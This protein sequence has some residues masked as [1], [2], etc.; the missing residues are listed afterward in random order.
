M[1]R[2][3]INWWIVRSCSWM[4]LKAWK[5]VG[6]WNVL[7]AKPATRVHVPNARTEN[8]PL[9]SISIVA[10]A[11][12][13]ALTWTR[14]RE[15]TAAPMNENG[16]LLVRIDLYEYKASA[17]VVCNGIFIRC[18]KKRVSWARPFIRVSKS[19]DNLPFQRICICIC[20]YDSVPQATSVS[21]FFRISTFFREYH[22]R[23]VN[24]F[25]CLCPRNQE[26][27]RTM[28]SMRKKAILLSR[29]H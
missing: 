18:F 6:N 3:K 1:Y 5:P 27:D 14:Q 21:L 16:N 11:T 8:V 25:F 29:A 7:S 9:R 17:V 23:E 28:V 20:V 22:S 19:E 2:W 15:A 12:A 13:F 10:A 24:T 4:A 26:A